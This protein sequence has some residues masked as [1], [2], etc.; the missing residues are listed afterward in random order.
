MQ[1]ILSFVWSKSIP[2]YSKYVT[3]DSKTK[4][5][6]LVV[7]FFGNPTN[8]TKT[9]TTYTW[10]TTNNKPPGP[11]IVIDQLEKLSCSQAQFMTLFLEDAQL[12]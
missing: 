5:L 2:N 10:G 12:C 8:K 1:I 7:F 6:S 3:L 4:C 9:R 11:I